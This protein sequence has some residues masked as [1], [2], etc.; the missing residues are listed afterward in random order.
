MGKSIRSKVKRKFRAIKREKFQPIVDRMREKNEEVIQQ[1]V[2]GKNSKVDSRDPLEKW[3]QTYG[4]D[5]DRKVHGP[6]ENKNDIDAREGAFVIDMNKKKQLTSC[7]ALQGPVFKKQ[8]PDSKVVEAVKM[9]M[10]MVGEKSMDL[11]KTRITLRSKTRRKSNRPVSK[12]KKG[13]KNY[14]F[15]HT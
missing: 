2:E 9:A 8:Q 13:K 15:Y 3:M 1:V 4:S 14:N 11:E 5:L 7:K 10:E 6:P 12:V